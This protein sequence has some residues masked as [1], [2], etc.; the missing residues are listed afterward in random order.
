VQVL[1]GAVTATATGEIEFGQRPAFWASALKGSEDWPAN[2]RILRV[3]ALPIAQLLEKARP[4][5][6]SC[7][8]EG[9]EVDVLAQ[10]LPGVRLIVVEIH[11]GDYGAAGTKRLFDALSAS[12][13]AYTPQ[14]SRGATVVFERTA[15]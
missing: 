5:V 13:F 6:L 11:P 14:G 3:P 4:T 8:V 10:P 1:H 12:G 2:A 15:P 7:D 9:A